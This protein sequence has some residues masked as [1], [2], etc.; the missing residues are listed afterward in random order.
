MPAYS[1]DRRPRSRSRSPPSRRSY[2]RRDS[3]GRYGRDRYDNRDRR[4]HQE[5]R[6]RDDRYDR[7]DRRS[8]ERPAPSRKDVANA[9]GKTEN[10]TKDMTMADDKPKSKAAPISLEELVA[11]QEEEKKA[12]SR[13]KFLTKEERAKLALERREKE[14]AEQKDRRMR[15]A[16]SKMEFDQK[17]EDESRRVEDASRYN[18]RNDRRYNR[19]DRDR[20][21]RRDNR[22]RE[23]SQ[24]PEDFDIPDG[25]T[26][27]EKEAIKS[28]YMGEERRK[29]KIRRMNEK[30]FVFDW[31]AGED[32]SQDFNP[33]Y[34]KRHHTQMF[35]R[36]HL[37]GIDEKEQKKQRSAFYDKL[38]E[39]RRTDEEK[40]RATALMDLDKKKEERLKWDDRHWSDKPLAQMKERDWRIFKE[41][42]NIS[43]KGGSIPNPLRSWQ[44]SS[45]PQKILDVIEQVGYKEP[46]PIQRQTIPIGLQNRD[47]IGIA[48]TGSGKTASF[49]IPML[50]YINDLPKLDESNMADGPYALIMAPTRE[51]AQ[52]IEQETL[53]FA[54]PLGYNCVSI[55]G[56]HAIEEQAFNLRN[57]AEIIIATPG[58]LR[59]CLDRRILVLNQCTYV[60]MDEADRMIDMGFEADVNF[61]LDALPV[62]NVKPDTVEA[63]NGDVMNTAM[64]DRGHKY[65]QTTMFSATMP[66]AVERLA[67]KYLR[68]PAVVTIGTA[69]QAV[70]TVEQKVEMVSGEEKKKIRLMELLNSGQYAPPIIVFVN[71]KKNVDL[72]AR[73]VNKSGYHAVT[74]HGSKSQEQRE[75][76][77]AQLKEGNADILVATD[78]A[79]RGIDVKN[80]SLVVNFDMAKNIEDYTHRI[81]RTGRAGQSGTALTFLSSTDTDVMYD[82]KQMLSKSS[83]SKVPPELA[84]HEAAQSKPGAFRPRRKHEETI[85]Q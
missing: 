27:K 43:C 64:D 57:G 52:Q 14:V 78:V 39:D 4:D 1:T 20:G 82:L 55:V 71:Q 22:R 54:T 38:L 34:A 8:P 75:L 59:D 13:P 42:F 61:I 37:A 24:T 63:E 21:K 53:K 62:S 77:L 10:T 56:G 33:L 31:D 76:A 30:K 73:T 45:L 16:Q 18:N 3:G 85:L 58:R 66:T 72:L 47:I 12:A 50:V 48:E 74:L 35:G 70:E 7:Y 65:R 44:E 26:E 2:D 81:G 41:D 69:G 17:V 68:R 15:E 29:R 49:V 46:S 28:R 83:L 32:T 60:V 25:L 40:G 5:S 11:K 6:H 80:V 79:G 36:G 51:L 67:K 84:N 9:N 19:E 23:R